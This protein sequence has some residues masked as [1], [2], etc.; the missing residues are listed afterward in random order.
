MGVCH[1][2]P[3]EKCPISTSSGRGGER[4]QLDRLWMAGAKRDAKGGDKRGKSSP[5]KHPTHPHSKNIDR[6]N[7]W[8]P[9]EGFM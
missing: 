5:R 7:H 1:I 9:P 4:A 6:L 3:T 8:I 2:P